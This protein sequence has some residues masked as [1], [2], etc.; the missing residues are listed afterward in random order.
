MKRAAPLLLLALAGCLPAF[1]HVEARRGPA[2]DPVAFFEGRTEGLGVLRVRGRA[3]VLVRVESVGRGLDG[4]G[5]ELT[6]TIRRGDGA[7]YSRTWTLRPDGPGRWTGAL[8]EA[9]GPVEAVSDGGRLTIRYGMGGGLSMHQELGLEA[10]GLVLNRSSVRFWGVPVA[11]LTEQIR[12]VG[13]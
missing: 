8:S 12:R 2:F 3:P 5:L 6:Q 9:D 13:R 7:P 4:G 10:P 1:P 11:R